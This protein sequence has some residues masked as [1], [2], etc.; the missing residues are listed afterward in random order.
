MSEFYKQEIFPF[1][2]KDWGEMDTLAAMYYNVTF[3]DDFGKILKNAYFEYI[4]IDYMQ[5][6]IELYDENGNSILKQEFIPLPC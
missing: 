2:W 5:G 1:T 4:Y 3:T 6:F